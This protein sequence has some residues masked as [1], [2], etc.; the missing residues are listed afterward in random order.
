MRINC[1]I[2]KIET[3]RFPLLLAPPLQRPDC[4][5]S[6]VGGERQ[7]VEWMSKYCQVMV[8]IDDRHEIAA[9]LNQLADVPVGALITGEPRPARSL[10][11]IGLNI[12]RSGQHSTTAHY[13]S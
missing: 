13:R 5:E 1:R 8:S 2:M 9:S 12:C 4:M 6:L 10:L 11:L 3:T 7:E